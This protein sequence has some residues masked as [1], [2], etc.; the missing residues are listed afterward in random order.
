MEAYLVDNLH[1]H[2]VYDVLVAFYVGI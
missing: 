1:H 2:G